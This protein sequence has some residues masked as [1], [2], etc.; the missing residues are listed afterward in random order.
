MQPSAV[1]EDQVPNVYISTF[2]YFVG[3]SLCAVEQWRK[4]IQH[5]AK[6]M[7]LYVAKVQLMVHV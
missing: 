2:L 7:G 1:E 3:L 4:V 5:F 6:C